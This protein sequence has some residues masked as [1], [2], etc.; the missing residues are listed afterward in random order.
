MYLL[1]APTA[2]PVTVNEAKAALRI[3]DTRFDALLPGLIASARA[4]AEQETGRQLVAQIWRTE[5]ADWPADTDIIAIHRATACAI[6]Y[7]D[8]ATFVSLAGAGYVFAPDSTTGNGTS[9]APAVGSSW[10]TLGDVA[11]GPR[12][13]IDLTAGVAA[14]SASAVPAGIQTFITALVGQI[15]QSPELTATAAVQA[16]PLLAR[17]LD[18]WRLHG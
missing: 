13:R 5:L 14:A 2:E 6:T 15:I 3:D 7:W 1:T 12:V 10:P 4:V 16:H 9:L 18:P 11:I 17:L 8:G